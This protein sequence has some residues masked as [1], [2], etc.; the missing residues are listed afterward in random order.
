MLGGFERALR[1]R[2]FSVLGLRF[3]PAQRC[4]FRALERA[5]GRAGGLIDP[6]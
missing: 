5:Y 3:G 2:R 1:S 6:T 4:A